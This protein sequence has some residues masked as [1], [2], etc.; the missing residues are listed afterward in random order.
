MMNTIMTTIKKQYVLV[1]VEPVYQAGDPMIL[2]VLKDRPDWQKGRL[3]LVGGK[4]EPNED[5]ATAALRELKEETGYEPARHDAIEQIG[6]LQGSSEIIYCF[7]ASVDDYTQPYPI[8]RAGETEVV[9][10]FPWSCVRKDKRLM[11]NLRVILPLALARVY[12]W[13][14]TYSDAPVTGEMNSLQI[15]IPSHLHENMKEQGP[16]SKIIQKGKLDSK[17]ET[18]FC[19]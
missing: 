17:W 19:D 14:I 2:L 18:L 7:R 9:R 12:D 3:N 10:W 1:H 5:V 16:V 15:D 8:P 6:I 13:E 4:V 11:S